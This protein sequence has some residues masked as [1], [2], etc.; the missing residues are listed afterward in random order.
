LHELISY[1]NGTCVCT[2]LTCSCNDGWTNSPEANCSQ[3]CGNG[4][5]EGSEQ[6]DDPNNACCQNCH[7]APSGVY[8]VYI[9][10][11][12]S[13][14]TLIKALSAV[15][16]AR[17]AAASCCVTPLVAAVSRLLPMPRAI[18]RIARSLRRS[19]SRPFALASRVRSLTRSR[20]LRVVLAS[21]VKRTSL[22]TQK[23]VDCDYSFV[24]LNG[25]CTRTPANSGSTCNYA[26][27]PADPC[28]KAICKNTEC[29]NQ[30]DVAKE[31][32]V[33]RTPG[34]M[35]ESYVCKTGVCSRLLVNESVVCG[36][37]SSVCQQRICQA[38][39]CSLVPFN[40][41]LEC[42][43]RIPPSFGSHLLFIHP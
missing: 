22:H 8:K 36:A 11:I 43:V 24:C 21:S 28:T 25:T 4:V 33:C 7:F 15:P 12:D 39:T 18:L 29:I 14:L 40:D 34:S 37:S 16:I 1:R 17:T 32:I 19:A 30:A 2:T 38:G 9:L 23:Q 6:C 26:P 35:C 31:N 3:K 5:V 10:C 42:A 27:T 20:P 13:S 41:G